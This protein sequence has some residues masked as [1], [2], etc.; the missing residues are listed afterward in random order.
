MSSGAHLKEK[1]KGKTVGVCVSGGLDSKTVCKKL[2]E[3]GL[4]VLAFSGDLGQ[5][6]EDDIQNVAK[7]MATCGVETVIV[8]L[9]NEMAEGCFDIVQA[10]ARYD[11]GY[12][13]TTGIGRFVTCFGLVRAMQEKGVGVLAHGA[14]G[15]GNDQMRFERYTNVLAPEME[16]FAP[17]RDASLLT[18]FP[19]RTEMVSYLGT[20]G[21]EAFVGPAKK[22]STDANLAGLSHE[23]E[24]LESIETSMLIVEAEMGVWPKD[25]PDAIENVVL[26]FEKGRCVAIN[27]TKMTA[28][29]VMVEANKVGGRC[30]L[31]MSHA[32]ENRI[33]GTKSR[34]V[35]EAP[36]M[37]LLGCS[38][39]FLYHAVLDR[40]STNLFQ[41]LSK[42]V[43]D[44]VYD[45]RWF[46]PCTRASMLAITELTKTATG[47]VTVGCYKGNVFFQSL[48]GVAQSLYNEADSSMEASDGLNPVSS[49]G[50]AEVQSVE[51][52]S[53]AAAG[54]IN[55]VSPLGVPG[56]KAEETTAASPSKKARKS[57]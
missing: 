41:S 49:Q 24:D 54:Q 28:L 35:Y 27:G 5:P 29:E 11:G 31:G 43:S 46:D 9:K 44:Q 36:G 26:D 40:R 15:R 52:R 37:E 32:L 10:Q 51:A 18:E 19:G 47:K 45:G 42:T 1:Y 16:V 55:G 38:L 22:Y 2:V 12:W 17:W 13:N 23:A 53:M 39:Q 48:Q 50:Y 33:I 34:G 8:D 57:K 21:I 20:F 6:D 3:D 56:A 4:K 30:G 14:T 7:R 25:A